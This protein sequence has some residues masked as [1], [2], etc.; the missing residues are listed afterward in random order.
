MP[1]QKWGGF[2]LPIAALTASVSERCRAEQNT[3]REPQ[4]PYLTYFDKGNGM[5]SY[6]INRDGLN[7]MFV[8]VH[9]DHVTL[10]SWN[11]HLRMYIEEYGAPRSRAV[12]AL[13]NARAKGLEIK[14]IGPHIF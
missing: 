7:T 5:N 6:S 14:K 8:H 3:R 4:T 10:N 2:T 13:K 9:T 12:E 11:E 1:P